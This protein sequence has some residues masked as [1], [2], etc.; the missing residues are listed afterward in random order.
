MS[1]EPFDIQI[2]LISRHQSPITFQDGDSP[3][4]GGLVLYQEGLSFTNTATGKRVDRISRTACDFGRYSQLTK[5]TIGH[6]TTLFPGQEHVISA[7]IRPEKIYRHSSAPKE[8]N[9][10]PMEGLKWQHAENLE[11]NAE[12]GIGLSD[13]FLVQS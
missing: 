10:T 6:Y 2:H 13:G 1:P 5:E 12:Y 7:S 9:G 4:F 3:L 11:D 8:T